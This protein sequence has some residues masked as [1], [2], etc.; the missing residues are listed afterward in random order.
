MVQEQLQ[1]AWQA[2]AHP[3]IRLQADFPWNFGTMAK[4][5]AVATFLYLIGSLFP[6]FLFS[7][8]VALLARI[9]PDLLTKLVGTDPRHPNMAVIIVP[10]V[11]S[12]VSGLGLELWYI[13]RC[14]RKEGLSLGKSL[15]FNLDSLGGSWWSAIW[16]A[17][18]AFALVMV[19]D[20]LLS[21]LPMPEVHDPAADLARSLSGYAFWVFAALAA[22]G[23]PLFEELIFRGFLF[24][25]CRTS[26]QKGWLGKLFRSERSAAYAAMVVSAAAFAGAHMTLTGFPGLFIMG[27]VL[28]ALYRRSG[29][30][31]CPMLLHGLNNL[32]AVILIYLSQAS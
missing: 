1:R 15:G 23:A 20:A 17:L 11:A 6:V 29:T 9:N 19:V 12:F 10:V 8:A 7:F 28:A 5:Y 16:R 14:F 26:F 32:T 31:I 30:L 24:N 18:V 2:L 22:V 3:K 27:I 4:Q 25:A 13:A 21:L